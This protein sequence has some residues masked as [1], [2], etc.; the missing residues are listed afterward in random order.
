MVP[1]F[2]DRSYGHR[3]H[4]FIANSSL[5]LDFWIQLVLRG[6]V[7]TACAERSSSA[8][9][10]SLS[11]VSAVITKLTAQSS[12]E[13]TVSCTELDSHV[14]MVVLGHNLYIFESTGRT[15]NVKPFDSTLRTASNI[16]IVDGVVAYKFPYT[17][18]TYPN[19]LE[20]ALHPTVDQ[21]LDP[22]IFNERR[23]CDS[24]WSTK[25]PLQW[26][27]WREP[28][29]LVSRFISTDSIAFPIF[30]TRNQM[31]PD[32]DNLNPHCKSFVSN[33]QSMLNFRGEIAEKSWWLKDPQI[34][35][36]EDNG[37]VR[38]I[39]K[40]T[41]E[42]W[43][44]QVDANIFSAFACCNESTEVTNDFAEAVNARAELSKFRSSKGSCTCMGSKEPNDLFDTETP[45][46]TD[47]DNFKKSLEAMLMPTQISFVKVQMASVEATRL[48]GVSALLLSKLW[49]VKEVLAEGAIE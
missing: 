15:C 18:K 10:I 24:Q 21:Q 2:Y 42:D 1:V 9:S 38:K 36:S 3:D 4:N 33:E 49:M 41:E 31:T 14:N 22:T 37:I 23:W 47:W 7:Y 26:S 43:N 6:V 40:V 17:S 45:F 46:T 28:W 19:C 12:S 11:T 29:N 20:V 8:I 13:T 27:N 30:P 35:E 25:D 39:A 32:A 48:K 34:F 44:C 5:S 16:L